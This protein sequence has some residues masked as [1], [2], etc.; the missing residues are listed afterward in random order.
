MQRK[1]SVLLLIVLSAL[2]FINIRNGHDW[3]DDF[4]QY[5]IQA[6]NIIHDKAQTANGLVQA[7]DKFAVA[8][9]PAGFP[10]LIS[11]VYAFSGYEITPYLILMTLLLIL[12]CTLVFRYYSYYLPA[13]IAFIMLLFFA[14][15]PETLDLKAQ[16][17][18]EI[19]FTLILTSLFLLCRRSE[20]TIRKLILAGV[21]SGLLVS[22][23]IAG[24]LIV[25][26]FLLW[27]VFNSVT[28]RDQRTP[29]VMAG[30]MLTYILTSAAVF[31]LIN[32]L[33]IPVPLGSLSGFYSDA[34]AA[35]EFRFISNLNQYAD[36]CQDIFRL[37]L[38]NTALWKWLCAGLILTGFVLR[39]LRFRSL[40]DWFFLLYILLLGAYPYASGG[41]RF[42]FPVFPLLILYLMEGI[43]FCTGLIRQ[44]VMNVVFVLTFLALFAAQLNSYA[45]IW[46]ERNKLPE[47]PQSQEAKEMFGFIRNNTDPDDVIVFPRARAMALYGERKTTYLIR[48]SSMTDNTELFRRMNVSLLVITKNDRPHPLEDPLL[49]EYLEHNR[50][51]YSLIWENDTF[52][53]Y[54]NK[55]P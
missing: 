28:S 2:L 50:S 36:E 6:A 37:P 30:N 21:L 1:L 14:F 17:L 4:A 29:M 51:D 3:G 5:L 46:N 11:P 25:P 47:G 13:G 32:S 45:V 8:A 20:I 12:L 22:M 49:R 40:P 54:R 43:K 42:L 19:P 33:L 7:S 10:L 38:L 39:L 52:E 55:L 23:R 16:I 18:S 15:H 24:L 34:A 9:Y 35:N 53:V 27:Q 31:L 41:F 26:A 48:N 44:P